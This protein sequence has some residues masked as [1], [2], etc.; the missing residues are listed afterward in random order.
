[1]K[2][3]MRH[4][5]HGDYTASLAAL[6]RASETGRQTIIRRI[7]E[8]MEDVPG[9]TQVYLEELPEAVTEFMYAD[10]YLGDV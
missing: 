3:T 7:L 4:P 8:A 6:K 1:M 10:M 5:E 9:Y 2:I